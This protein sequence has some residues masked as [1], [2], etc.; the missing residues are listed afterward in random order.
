MFKGKNEYLMHLTSRLTLNSVNLDNKID[1]TTPPSVFIGSWNYPKVFAGPMICQQEGDTS[2]YDSPEKWI[3]SS[4]TTNDIINFRLNL[5]RGKQQLKVTDLSNKLVDKLQDISL[6]AKSIDSEAVFKGK[7]QGQS[8]TDD[9]APYGPSGV[10]KDFEITNTR[11]DKPLEKAYYDWDLRAKDAVLELYS[12]D[13]PFS[14]IQ[15]AFSVG[16]FGGKRYRRLVPTRWSITACD[17]ILADNLLRQV[18]HNDIIDYYRVHEFDS[19][20]NYYSIILLP[21]A[22]QYE[23]MEAFLKIIGSEELLFSDHEKNNGKKGYSCVGGCYYSCKFGVLEALDREGIQAGAIILR[24]A[25]PGYVPLGVFNV[26]ENVRQ[27]LKTPGRQFNDF[28][29]VLGYVGSRLRLPLSRF[30]KESTVLKD[31]LFNRQT[32]LAQFY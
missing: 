12:K 30:I 15:K 5:V 18:R 16:A 3:P 8:L 19:L 7:P 32:R 28:K 11:W 2:F 23:W 29:D 31:Y 25:Y 13:T 22:W 9:H 14:N 4:T 6:S 10:L 24:E 26:R 27:A 17:T 21:T 20:H 1:G